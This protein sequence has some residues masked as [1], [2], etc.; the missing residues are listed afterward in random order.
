MACCTDH[1][2]KLEEYMHEPANRKTQLSREQHR[3]TTTTQ[4]RVARR[5]HDR[6]RSTEE[7]T[8]E[9][10]VTHRHTISC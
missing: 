10:H 3:A 9:E 8:P 1:V 7:R 5:D 2:L 6:A 4:Q